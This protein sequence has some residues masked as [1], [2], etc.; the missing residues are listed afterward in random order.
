MTNRDYTSD[1]AVAKNLGDAMYAAAKD[2]VESH[3][4]RT[5]ANLVTKKIE[6]EIS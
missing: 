5:I 3:Y 6:H 4:A 1:R 2:A